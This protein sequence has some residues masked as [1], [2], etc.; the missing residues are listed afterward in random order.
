MLVN[1]QEGKGTCCLW[2]KWMAPF[3]G[4]CYIVS[5]G[6]VNLGFLVS[7][8]PARS[9][10]RWIPG[11][12]K[13]TVSKAEVGR[14]CWKHTQCV[15]F[16]WPK[17]IILHLNTLYIVISLLFHCYLWWSLTATHASRSGTFWLTYAQGKACS[18]SWQ[19]H[20]GRDERQWDADVLTIIQI[21]PGKGCSPALYPARMSMRTLRSRKSFWWQNWW[22]WAMTLTGIICAHRW[23]RY[24][25]FVARGARRISRIPPKTFVRLALFL[26]TSW[27][28]L[29][30]SFMVIGGMLQPDQMFLTHLGPNV[31]FCNL[32]SCRN[33]KMFVCFVVPL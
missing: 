16:I 20:I 10:M 18:D 31:T 21:S 23:M 25:R 14:C 1:S 3:C 27:I 26:P 6:V 33:I 17:S 5:C 15:C 12:K 8:P 4:T 28:P 30:H 2:M 32:T 13:N 11:L 24:K 29:I 7:F 19:S 9:F 22:A